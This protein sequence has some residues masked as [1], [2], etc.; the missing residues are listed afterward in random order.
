VSLGATF[1]IL[2]RYDVN[3][4]HLIQSGKLA[5]SIGQSRQ[6]GFIKPYLAE[7]DEHLGRALVFLG[8]PD[9]A[10]ITLNK[11]DVT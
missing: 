7:A 3:L 6:P 9:E 5:E 10:R 11:P 2:F 4:V 1:E 8:E